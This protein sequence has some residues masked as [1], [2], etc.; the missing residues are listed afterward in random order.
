[1]VVNTLY[2]SKFTHM[3]SAK[4][5]YVI[6][7]FPMAKMIAPKRLHWRPVRPRENHCV[8]NVKVVLTTTK[9][10]YRPDEKWYDY[11]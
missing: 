7:E 6:E 1:M 10:V 9:D 11:V 2:I 4:D 3:K 5:R 8:H